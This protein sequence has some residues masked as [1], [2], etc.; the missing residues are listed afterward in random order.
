VDRF[1]TLRIFARVAEAAS[2]TKA[3]DGLNLPRST[4]STAVQALEARIG[5]RLLNRTTRRVSLTEDGR[6][7]YERCM[8]LLGDL[9]ETET[10][11]RQSARPTGKLRVDVPG[12]I[13]RLVIAPALPDF[14]AKYPDVDIEMGVSDRRIDLVQEGV[15][16]AIR[17]GTLGDSGLVAR[18]I[19]D[20]DIISCASRSYIARYGVPRKPSDLSRH[21]AVN[22]ASPASGR[23]EPWEYMQ[24][25]EVRTVAMRSSTAPSPSPH[26]MTGS[27]RPSPRFTKRSAMRA[28][29]SPYRAR[30]RTRSGSDA[31]SVDGDDH[32]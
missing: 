24:D 28:V 29:P 7:F 8:R 27:P 10:L 19:G 5:A 31:S 11:F 25:G 20:L 17:V 23:I 21:W 3:A 22:Y 32:T 30:L 6:A 14:F 1:D 4:V 13:G 26:R 2:F 16:C 9:E 12:R 18:R 15:D